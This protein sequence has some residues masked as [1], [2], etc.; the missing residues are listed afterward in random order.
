MSYTKY[1]NY[2][3]KC[4]KKIDNNMAESIKRSKDTD[5]KALCLY[6]SLDSGFT[7]LSTYVKTMFFW[8]I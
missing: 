3:K 2:W 5:S 7:A 1:Y 6:Y 4:V 8:N